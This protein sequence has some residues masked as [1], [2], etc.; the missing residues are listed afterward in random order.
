MNFHKL[1]M[2]VSWFHGLSW[3]FHGSYM[4]IQKKHFHGIFHG[5]STKMINN[6]RGIISL[7]FSRGS[8][9][10]H[11]TVQRR[12][13]ANKCISPASIDNNSFRPEP[14]S[15]LAAIRSGS[16]SAWLPSSPVTNQK[17]RGTQP[18]YRA[19]TTTMTTQQ[20]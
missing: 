9:V 13:N 11:C 18:F 14:Q 3:N 10:L 16:S 12:M 2:E 8:V 1:F 19:A 17:R 4:N 5:T 20:Q 15:Q 6:V 7:F